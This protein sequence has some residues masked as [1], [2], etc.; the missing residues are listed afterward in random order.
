M[1]INSKQSNQIVCNF[2]RCSSIS[3]GSSLSDTLSEFI[4]DVLNSS[5]YVKSLKYLK[6]EPFLKIENE[7]T[8]AKV[9]HIIFYRIPRKIIILVHQV[10]RKI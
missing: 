2:A 10:M 5:E 4:Y 6:F 9:I 3:T 7:N 1:R 8:D